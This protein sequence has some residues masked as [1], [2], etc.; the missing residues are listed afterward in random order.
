MMISFGKTLVMTLALFA[1]TL[2]SAFAQTVQDADAPSVQENVDVQNGDV[3]RND[4]KD[5]TQI[6]ATPE[7]QSQNE[8]IQPTR[9]AE[10]DVPKQK[11][12]SEKALCTGRVPYNSITSRAVDALFNHRPNEVL[13][14]IAPIQTKLHCIED[15]SAAVKLYAILGIAYLEIDNQTESDRYF[16]DAI[17]LDPYSDIES[18]IMLP[19]NAAQR[20]QELKMEVELRRQAH[21]DPSVIVRMNYVPVKFENHPFWINFLPLGAGL[22]QM[23]EN[24][25]GFTYLSTQLAGVVLSIM[26]A[27]V[28]ESYR[29]DNYYFLTKNVDTAKN[30]RIVEYTGIALLTAS[31]FA[32]VIHAIFVHK[33]VTQ[34]ILSPQSSMPENIAYTISPILVDHGAGISYSTTF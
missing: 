30:W 22:F 8:L 7:A 16:T 17:L 1:L 3:T 33:P 2:S 14:I 18:L 5:L 4:P 25:W 11:I 6:D 31:Y 29:E 13:D 34:T 21:E 28:V 27:V 26:G 10:I 20:L 9:D 19:P 15:T 24:A 32:N 23:H 12:P